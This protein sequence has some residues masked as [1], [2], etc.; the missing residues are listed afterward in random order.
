[1]R[2]LNDV[3]TVAENGKILE[4]ISGSRLYG[5]ATPNSDEDKLG[6]FLP[7]IRYILGIDKVEEVDFSIQ[8]KDAFGKNTK[9]SIDRKFYAYQKFC[10]LAMQNNPNIL[11]LLY[12]SKDSIIFINDYGKD[13]IANRD[14]FLHRGLVGR[15]L[16]YA[17]SQKHKMII[18]KDKFKE[19]NIILDF[20]L[21]LD[22]KR[23][24]DHLRENK[25]FL[26]IL[27]SWAKDND[28][29]KGHSFR[30]HDQ[31]LTIGDINLPW[32]DMIK[33]AIVKLKE[34]VD[35]GTNRQDLIL[36]YGYD[37]KFASHLIRLL[38]EG[39][40]LLE[41]QQITFPLTNASEILDI[42]LGKW[43]LTNI[44]QYS[45]DLESKMMELKKTTTLP[46]KMNRDL[47]ND[48]IVRQMHKWI[49][50][51]QIGIKPS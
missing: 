31:F 10:M 2:T 15:F 29:S 16:G 27:N 48:F 35:N 28:N 13:L 41:N 49:I 24:I 46:K 39:I 14:I 8:F 1:M 12:P 37:T 19:M 26:A 18:K 22:P 7:S 3:E 23:T 34:R 11:E 17:K 51:S 9:E 25:E 33:S 44:I 43:H 4:V 32:N 20:F 50:E 30:F 42:K 47:V 21:S 40:E 6:I 45:D 38:H 36:N 5:T